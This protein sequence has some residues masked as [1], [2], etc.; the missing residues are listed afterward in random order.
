MK[1]VQRDLKPVIEK[2][3]IVSGS[4]YA[5]CAPINKK[6]ILIEAA[7]AFGTGHH[8]TTLSCLR[9]LNFLNKGKISPQKVVDIGC[10]TG[11]LAI[12]AYKVFKTK[13]IASDID[14]ISVETAKQN[15]NV[16]G[17]N[18]HILVCKAKALNNF[19]IRQKAPFDLIFANILA[20]PL[21]KMALTIK[22]N[23]A[24]GGYIIISVF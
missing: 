20:R 22:S 6:S 11:I 13:A 2:P 5:K 23:S 21:F 8:P 19:F 24:L 1:K 18:G 14:I 10:G 4:Y 3:L 15:V 16:N 17:L 9:A 7:M 12:S